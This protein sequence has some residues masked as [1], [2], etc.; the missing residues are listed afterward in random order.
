MSFVIIYCYYFLTLHFPLWTLFSLSSFLFFFRSL[1][2]ILL[3]CSFRL[4][5]NVIRS[6]AI[7][8]LCKPKLP[9]ILAYIIEVLATQVFHPHLAR[10]EIRGTLVWIS[11]LFISPFAAHCIFRQNTS[12]AIAFS[13][14]LIVLF[15]QLRLT[16]ILRYI[17]LPMLQNVAWSVAGTLVKARLRIK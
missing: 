14:L 3:S 11:H 5:N 7:I 16:K 17:K 2:L 8:F 4:E 12:S 9:M 6:Q 1:S 15:I 10:F 13:V